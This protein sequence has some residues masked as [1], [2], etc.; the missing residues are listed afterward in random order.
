MPIEFEDPLAKMPITR[1]VL[2]VCDRWSDWSTGRACI[3]QMLALGLCSYGGVEV[4]RLVTLS[5]WLLLDY[6]IHVL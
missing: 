6:H 4:Y 1:R 5:G 3:N 2:M